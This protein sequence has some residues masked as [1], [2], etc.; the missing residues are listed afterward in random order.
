[1]SKPGTVV[2]QRQHSRGLTMPQLN[3]I[4]LLAAGKTDKDT[5]E[6]LGLHRTTVSKWRL[7]DPHFSAALNRR[8]AE[9]W[10]AGVDKLRALIPK[11]LAVLEAHM[12]HRGPSQLKA[13]AIILKLVPLTALAE[14]PGPTDPDEI[15]QGIV[16]ARRATATDPLAE[17]IE[18]ARGLPGRARLTAEVWGELDARLAEEELPLASVS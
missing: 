4:D 11:A 6:A 15:V 1:M 18:E 9:V 3:A 13:A 2:Y 10:S 16:A 8:R 7:Y 17:I 12:K 14:A 5:A